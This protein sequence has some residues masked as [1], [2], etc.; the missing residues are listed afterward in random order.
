MGRTRAK[1]TIVGAGN[2]G[3]SAAQWMLSHRL[4][5]VVLVD[6]IEGMPQGK[7]LDL[8]EAAPIEGVDFRITGTNGYDETEQSDIVVIVAGIAFQPLNPPPVGGKPVQLVGEVA[9]NAYGSCG[10]EGPESDGAGDK[11]HAENER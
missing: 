6:V 9:T 11:E 1:V 5:D 8:L 10:L 2:V 7:A 4:A 3:H